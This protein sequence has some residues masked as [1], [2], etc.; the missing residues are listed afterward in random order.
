MVTVFSLVQPMKALFP[1]LVTLLGI[2]TEVRLE[3]LS[4]AESHMLVTFLPMVTETIQTQDAKAPCP[5][6][7][8]PSGMVTFLMLLSLTSL[9]IVPVSSN[10]KISSLIVEIIMSLQSYEIIFKLLYPYL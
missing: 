7:V 2:L 6:F 1:M 3:Q 9:R 10:M 4:K 5:I 8:T